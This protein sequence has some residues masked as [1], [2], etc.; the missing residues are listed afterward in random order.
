MKFPRVLYLALI[1]AVLFTMVM[2]LSGANKDI[3]QL[4]TQV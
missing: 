3:I 4:Q 2:P 1:G